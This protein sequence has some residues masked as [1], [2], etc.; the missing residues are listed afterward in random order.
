M[1]A[2]FSQKKKKRK[3]E[4]K[5][6]TEVK[7]PIQG[8]ACKNYFINR[9]YKTFLKQIERR[10]KQPGY[11]QICLDMSESHIWASFYFK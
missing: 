8:C 11:C 1:N 3:K 2:A 7:V 6:T 4:K 5:N 9:N 10:S